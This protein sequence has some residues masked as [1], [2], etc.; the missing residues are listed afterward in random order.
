MN[1]YDFYKTVEGKTNDR[2]GDEC[3]AVYSEVSKNNGI[4]LHALNIKSEASNVSPSIYMDYFYEEYESGRVSMDDIVEEIVSLYEK[5]KIKKPFDIDY[6]KDYEAARGLIGMKMIDASRNKALLQYVPYI[7]YLDLAIVFF[8]RVDDE[9]MGKGSILIKKDLMDD[10]G[11]DEEE[12]YKCA[13]ENIRAND[14]IS[15]THIFTMLKSMVPKDKLLYE[16]F[17]D[18]EDTPMYVVTNQEGYYGATAML[19][20]DLLESF[21]DKLGDDYYILPCSVHELIILPTGNVDIDWLKEVVVTINSDKLQREV[22]L[23]DSIYYFDRENKRV[24]RV[25]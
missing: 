11:V 25:A 10:W 20:E 13:Y 24:T 16:W 8:I 2:L 15:M 17:D 6:I 22:V 23:S 9:D 7:P 12:L 5:H 19:Y 4:I 14:V 3:E 1:K 21:G 18:E